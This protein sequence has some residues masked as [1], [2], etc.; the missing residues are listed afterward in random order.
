MSIYLGKVRA[1]KGQSLYWLE[2]VNEWFVSC[3]CY[4]IVLFTDFVPTPELQYNYGWLVISFTLLFIA[5]N[6]FYLLRAQLWTLW[7]VFKKYCK[8]FMS[9]QGYAEIAPEKKKEPDDQS[10]EDFDSVEEI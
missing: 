7:L 2:L 6:L 4:G 3:A 1:W 10:S 5:V 8:L 9:T